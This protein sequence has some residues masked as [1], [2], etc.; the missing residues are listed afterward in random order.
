[1]KKSSNIEEDRAWT[2]LQEILAVAGIPFECST[3][4]HD[5]IIS[6]L[7]KYA[8]KNDILSKNDEKALPVETAHESTKPTPV[9]KLEIRES[10]DDNLLA[11]EPT[12]LPFLPLPP[13]GLSYS[14]RHRS[15]SNHRQ[16]YE[17]K[18][19]MQEENFPI[20]VALEMH[21][22]T[23]TYKEVRP[24]E[25][26]PIPVMTE[27]PSLFDSEMQAILRDNNVPIPVIKPSVDKARKPNLDLHTFKVPIRPR[28]SHRM[29]R[30]LWELTNSKEA[31]IA[32]ITAGKLET[33][34]SLLQKGAD[35]NMQNHE[36]QTALMAAVSF[37]HEAITR[38]LIEHGAK[39]DVRTHKGESALA[40]AALRGFDRILRMLI[41]SG[42]DVNCGKR[43][44]KTALSQAAAYGQDRIVQLLLDYGA[45]INAVN[46]SGETALAL[47]A[48][49]GN[50]RVARVLLDR[51]ARVDHYGYPGQTPLYK[52]VTADS[53]QMV[54]LLMER[55]ADPFVKMGYGRTETAL[56]YAGRIR[57]DNTLR[58]FALYGY[59]PGGPDRYQYF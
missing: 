25:N 12:G 55:G 39:M 1:M 17:A 45:E 57:R 35:V 3:E 31:F 47:A 33:A 11:D 48:L 52:A 9:L 46:G 14:D 7:R 41:A 32:A 13:K 58:T 34:E 28:K 8:E 22:C 15:N 42:A 6:I 37:G 44:G 49:N 59:H 24:P 20:P 26:L 38:L 29:S 2:R 30:M 36:G 27:A 19:A 5:F 16:P 18:P 54:T 4:H 10:L 51:G 50:M 56:A 21:G 43:V 40:T 53:E 23:N